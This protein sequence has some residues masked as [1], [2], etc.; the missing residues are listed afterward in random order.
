[1]S[2]YVGSSKTL[3]DLKNALSAVL[4]TEGPFVGLCWTKLKP[5]G[6]EERLLWGRHSDAS[7]FQPETLNPKLETLNLKPENLNPKHE[8]LNP[9][10]ENLDPKPSRRVSRT[11]A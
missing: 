6:P 5:K 10:P 8:N 11:V 1:M 9:K 2:A 3:K 7:A 4:S